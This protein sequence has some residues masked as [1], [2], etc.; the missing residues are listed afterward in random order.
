MATLRKIAIVGS[1]RIPFCRA[2]SG[3]TSET[4]LSMLA[5]AIGGLFKLNASISGAEVGCQGEVGSASAMAAAALCATSLVAAYN[6][7]E[8]KVYFTGLETAGVGPLNNASWDARQGTM[9]N[10]ILLSDD[11]TGLETSAESDAVSY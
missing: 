6:A 3:Y 4:N 8:R 9:E 1:A 7:P 2:Y 10:P 11:D 5:A